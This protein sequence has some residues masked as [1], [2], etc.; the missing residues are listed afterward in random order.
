MLVKSLFCRVFGKKIDCY[1]VADEERFELFGTKDEIIPDQYLK[2]GFLHHSSKQQ[3]TQN[4]SHCINTLSS[5]QNG[6]KQLLHKK[7]HTF[8][9][10]SIT[11]Q[12]TAHFLNQIT[13]YYILIV[14]INVLM[15]QK[16]LSQDK[17]YI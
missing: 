3:I 17:H 7:L 11:A 1:L 4:Y 13:S 14:L 6:D 5:R 2:L 10:T 16:L 15:A 12:K 9:I 8:K